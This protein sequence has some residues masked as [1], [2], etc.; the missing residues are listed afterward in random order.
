MKV[1]RNLLYG[2]SAFKNF[3]VTKNL[4]YIECCSKS[5]VVECLN[6]THIFSMKM[7]LHFSGGS[8]DNDGGMNR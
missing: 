7:L 4:S 5:S 2:C 8:G 3:M 1:D 6:S